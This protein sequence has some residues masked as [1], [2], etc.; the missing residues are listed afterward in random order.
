MQVVSDVIGH[1]VALN[2]YNQKADRMLEDFRVL[3]NAVEGSGVFTEMVSGRRVKRG[4]RA[5]GPAVTPSSP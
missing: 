3:N 2:F 5:A 1:S 4:E